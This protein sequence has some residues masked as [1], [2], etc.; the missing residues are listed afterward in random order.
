MGTDLRPV[1]DFPMDDF[2]YGFDNIADVLTISPLLVELYAYAAE[3]LVAEALD[4]PMTEPELWHVEAETA[5]ST[6][7]GPAPNGWNVWSNGELY[8]VINV[9]MNGRYEISARLYATRAGEDL[10]RS[11]LMV[12]GSLVE[13]FDIEASSADA[14]EVITAE[15]DLQAG[16]RQ[17][18]VTFDNDYHVPEQNLDRNLIVDWLRL[19]GPVGVELVGNPRRE[20]LLDCGE[21][22][23]GSEA[24]SRFV[25]KR[26]SEAAFRRPT[27]DHEV[28]SLLGLVDLAVSMGDDWDV[29]IGLA[30]EKVLSS[31]HFIYRMEY[32][33]NPGQSEAQPLTSFELASRSYFLWSSMPDAELFEK[34]LDGS[35]LDKTVLQ[36]QASRMLRDS[37]AVALVE[38]FAGQWLHIRAIEDAAPD[39]WYFPDFDGLFE[40]PCRVKCNTLCVRF[41]LG[42]KHAGLT[43]GG[44]QL[45]GSW[46]F[47]SLWDI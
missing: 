19:R 33:E 1:D 12:D 40:R 32:G 45:G 39:L 11:S 24:C 18:S 37:K 44:K 10:A 31:P 2:G 38:N 41:V 28:E 22:E 7:G 26:F 3:N 25:L 9:P 47:I 36:A 15:V 13:S 27:S 23:T 21:F 6:V 34:A 30:M 42:S 4:N 29:G 17:I 16:L 5:E 35:L 8:A 46:A 14:M 20:L 43:S